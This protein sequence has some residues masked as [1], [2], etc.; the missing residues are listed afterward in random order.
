M[1]ARSLRHFMG[2]ES[3]SWN[4]QWIEYDPWTTLLSRFAR[5]NIAQG[6][7][8]YFSRASNRQGF[9]VDNLTWPLVG[10]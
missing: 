2:L 4:Q 9:D 8:V 7:T 10:C 3:I 6:N 1:Y 5:R